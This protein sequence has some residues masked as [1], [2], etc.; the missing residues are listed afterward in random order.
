MP[1]LITEIKDK[2]GNV[3]RRRVQKQFVGES[4][5]EQHH[6]KDVNINTIVGRYKKTGLL[7]NYHASGTYGDFTSIGEFQEC[8]DR[9]FEAQAGFDSLP[10]D[11]RKRFQNDPG[12]LIA[13]LADE[14][15][16][17]KA[18]ELGLIEKPS[19]TPVE[20]VKETPP[21]PAE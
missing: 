4:M 5:T 18:I 9:V 20:P 19:Q 17:E 8:I 3:I 10:S 13:F 15:N 6:R 7:P 1:N 21:A 2:D 11:L 16:R 14:K 12:K